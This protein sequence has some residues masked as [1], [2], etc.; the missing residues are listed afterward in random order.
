MVASIQI[1]VELNQSFSWPRS[2][3][4]CKAPIAD[5]QAR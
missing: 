1:S 4:S 5:A 2:S 3:I